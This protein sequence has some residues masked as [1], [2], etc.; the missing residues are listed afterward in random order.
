RD[1]SSVLKVNDKYYVWYTK[2]VGP[3]FGKE[4]LDP[5]AK[6]FPWDYADIY[7]ATS[8]DGI[9]WQ[10]QGCA[11]HRGGKGEYDE[12]TICT[13]DV[14]EHN[15]KY[16]LV[17]QAIPQGSYTGCNENVAMAVA[18][19]PDGP[20]IKTR[21]NI[22]QAMPSGN[23]FGDV[24][25]DSY[26]KGKFFGLTHD[27]SLYYYNRKFYLYYKCSSNTDKLKFAGKDTRWGVAISEDI[28]G[29]YEH[30]DF[31]PVTN[32]GHETMLW[33]YN[34]GI[35]ALL[36]RDGP[37]KN[38]IQ[39]AKDGVNFEIMAVTENTP[40]AGGAFRGDN[41]DLSPLEGIRWGLCH[42]DE[43]A[44]IWNYIIRFDLDQRNDPYKL[45]LTYPIPNTQWF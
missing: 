11:V 22:L 23:W 38:T 18:E 42:C 36:N 41:T 26:N 33:H 44:S 27:P 6:K 35:G 12:R 21:Q 7:Y 40:Q 8:V 30:S 20:F 34:G 9:N 25:D 28:L 32:S 45:P 24:S 43:R 17:Y 5:N 39:Y 3:H 37:E 2:S 19:S 14:L 29:P 13:P 10:E 16:Y 31:N 4:V 1:P 15:G